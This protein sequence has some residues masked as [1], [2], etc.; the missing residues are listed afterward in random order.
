MSVKLS[1]RDIELYNQL[2]KSFAATELPP[3]ELNAFVNVLLWRSARLEAALEKYGKH[4]K[5]C[6]INRASKEMWPPCTCG[7]SNVLNGRE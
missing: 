1:D 2:P 5:F 6:A 4:K 7:L 3:E